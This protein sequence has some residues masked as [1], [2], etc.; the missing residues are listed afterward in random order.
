[1]CIEMSP[2]RFTFFSSLHWYI[3][4]GAGNVRHELRS[5]TA[6]TVGVVNVYI[7]GN[8]YGRKLRW[9]IC[10]ALMLQV[11]DKQQCF[12]V[13]KVR[14]FEHRKTSWACSN[15]AFVQLYKYTTRYMTFIRRNDNQET[16][17]TFFKLVKLSIFIIIII[18]WCQISEI[19]GIRYQWDGFD[20]IIG[21]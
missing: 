2:N 4:C 6:T 10:W 16:T 15:F 18:V 19:H 9:N 17:N 21:Q 11:Y 7:S 12:Y 13:H 3:R 1:M 20:E 5:T 8:D 14:K